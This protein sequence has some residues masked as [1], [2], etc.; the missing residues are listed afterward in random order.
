M[1]HQIVTGERIQQICD[2]YFGFKD[3]F[4][5]NPVIKQQIDKHFNLDNLNME[6]SNPYRIFCYSHRIKDLSN[7]IHFLK[8][9]F[10]L[11]THNSDGE[12]RDESETHIILN[13]PN[14]DK[15][16]AQNI[17][18]NNSKLF[19]L[20]IGIANSQW[21]YGNINVYNNELVLYNSLNKS[22][23]V[24]FNFNIDTNKNKRSACFNILKDKLLWLDNIS[25]ADN[26]LRLSKYKFC[27][28]PEGNGVDTHRFWEALYL[29]TIPIVIKSEF[30]NILQKN[31]VPL[32]ILDTWND[33][34]IASLNYND[35]DFTNEKFV[36]IMN[37][38]KI[39]L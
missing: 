34:N 32:L 24:Y 36:K 7:K 31:N 33:L 2:V 21:P 19:F 17:C 6:Y 11:I 9:R 10:I 3:D 14:L 4:D 35:Y 38:Y 28:C 18:F 12:I 5:F 30:T 23:N 13:C 27:I 26:I 39:L 20:P 22:E 25:P 29:K 8:N 1:S 15:W 16:Y 37:L